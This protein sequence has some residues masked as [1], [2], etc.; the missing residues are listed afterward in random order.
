MRIVP[1]MNSLKNGIKSKSANP[2]KFESN[3]GFIKPVRSVYTGNASYDL[4]WASLYDE[5]IAKDLK[6]MG[7]I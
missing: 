1:V 6:L 4:A 5:N 7:L 3:N 2:T